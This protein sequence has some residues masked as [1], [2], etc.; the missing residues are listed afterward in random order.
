[1][2][3]GIATKRGYPL[4]DVMKTVIV[5]SAA[6]LAAGCTCSGGPKAST[7]AHANAPED[8]ARLAAALAGRVAGPPQDCVNQADLGGNESYGRGAI[9]FGDRTDDVVYVNRPPAGCP[10]LG[11][12]RALKV[13]TTAAQLCRGDI[14]TVFDPVGGIE[15]GSCGLGEF[16]PYSRAR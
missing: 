6:I 14:V 7:R 9:L 1:M 10:D 2:T 4:E 13:R 8:E 12:G 15:Y 3:G 16:T 11:V 5:L